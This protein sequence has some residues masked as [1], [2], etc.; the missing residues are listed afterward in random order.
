MNTLMSIV[1]ET[2]ASAVGIGIALTAFCGLVVAVAGRR[3]I[4]LLLG[5]LR[6]VISSVTAPWVYMRRIA[7]D[8]A[9]LGERGDKATENRGLYLVHKLLDLEK[10]AL[11]M[12]SIAILAGGAVASWN[13]LLPEPRLREQ[14]KHVGAE[15]DKVKADLAASE[16]DELSQASQA[17]SYIAAALV[18]YR[19]PREAQ[20]RESQDA[21]RSVETELGANSDTQVLMDFLK[22][23]TSNAAG[24]RANEI[25]QT[26]RRLKAKM[27]QASWAGGAEIKL[28]RWVDAWREAA[29]ATL[30]LAD[31][32]RSVR[33]EHSKSR[34]ELARTIEGLRSQQKR[35][36]IRA[37][38]IDSQFHLRWSG[39]AFSLVG[40][41]MLFLAVV[42]F[43]GLLV[44]LGGMWI[45]LSGDVREIRH[46]ARGG[47]ISKA[48][49]DGDVGGA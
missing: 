41:L 43:L 12:F 13:A 31:A 27:E 33:A 42:W 22:A 29:I 39:F 4:G 18:D 1:R 37:A 48:R 2:M 25:A 10:A 38:E 23:E 11:L 35:L 21:M 16:S 45:A 5:L 36:E 14:R 17:E 20:L 15:L 7:A 26:H 49:A 8:L 40:T 46:A 32:E 44:E 19:R 9:E 3:S 6:I 47:V 30:E 34:G 24:S 28:I